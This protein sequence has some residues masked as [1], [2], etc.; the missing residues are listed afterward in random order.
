MCEMRRELDGLRERL[1]QVE[2]NGCFDSK[3]M[4]GGTNSR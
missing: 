2:I 1:I 3:S 4:T